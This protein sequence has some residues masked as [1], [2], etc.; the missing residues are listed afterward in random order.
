ML[1]LSKRLK[2]DLRY[3]KRLVKRL[4]DEAGSLSHAA[5]GSLSQSL[6]TDYVV[7]TRLG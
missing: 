2:V 6:A 7:L 4:R 5:E 1:S 3:I